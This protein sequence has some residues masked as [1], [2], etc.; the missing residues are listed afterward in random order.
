[1]TKGINVMD[2]ENT[3]QAAPKKHRPF[4]SK[5][6]DAVI[7]LRRQRLY[8]RQLEGLGSRD[9]VQQHAKTE[10][11]S[12]ATAWRDW[13]QVNAWNKEDWEREREDMIARIQGMRFKL[14][15]TAYKKGHLQ[16]AA[17]VLD[18]LGRVL[19]EATPEQVAVQVPNLN[20]Q[21][22]QKKD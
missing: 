8:R 14:Y 2:G 16:V 21:I 19:G 9:L 1:M 12:M 5:N 3:E 6:P 18:S 4:G 11:I 20:I 10:Q 17:G 13:A 7:E 15:H 22:E